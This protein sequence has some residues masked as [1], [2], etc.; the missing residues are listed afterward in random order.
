VVDQQHSGAT[1]TPV[2]CDSGASDLEN[3]LIEV[4]RAFTDPGTDGV[5][6][7]SHLLKPPVEWPIKESWDPVA[8][9]WPGIALAQLWRDGHPVWGSCPARWTWR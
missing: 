9:R 5:I 4:G 1:A 6:S 8:E 7:E 3:Y 2:F